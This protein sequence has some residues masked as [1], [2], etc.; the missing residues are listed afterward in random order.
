MIRSTVA[1]FNKALARVGGQQLESVERPWEDTELGRLCSNNFTLVLEEA[2]ARHPWSFATVTEELAL[3]DQETPGGG[4]GRRGYY[5]RYAQPEG[6]LKVIDLVEG[7]PYRL[8]GADILTDANP[9]HLTYVGPC[10]DPQRWTPAFAEALAWSLAGVLATAKTNDQQLAQVCRQEY[11][12]AVARAWALDANNSRLR[13]APCGW[14]AARFGGGA[15][16]A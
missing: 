7:K 6:C 11:E 15:W 14:A 4:T 16:P 12:V 9:A 3:K 2:L 13:K 10:T 5:W 1:I 8:E